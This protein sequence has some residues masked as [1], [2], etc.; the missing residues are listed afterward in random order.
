M[1]RKPTGGIWSFAT[2]NGGLNTRAGQILLPANQTRKMRNVILNLQG[3]VAK[4]RGLTEVKKLL[5]PIQKLM[6]YENSDYTYDIM[7]YNYPY[8][9]KVDPTSGATAIIKNNILNLGENPEY[10]QDNA[11]LMHIT[12]GVNAPLRYNGFTTAATTWPPVYTATNSAQVSS[13]YTQAANPTTEPF[14]HDCAFSGMRMVYINS[15]RGRIFFSEAN[16]TTDF[17][18]NAG[19]PV[20]LDVPFFA[21][22]P[23]TTPFTAILPITGGFILYTQNGFGRVAGENTPILGITDPLNFKWVNSKIGTVAPRMAVNKSNNEHFVYSRYGLFDIKLS[24]DFDQTRPGELSFDIQQDLDSIGIGGMARGELVNSPHE[25][26][27]YMLTPRYR[28][29]MY[30]D[31]IWKFNYEVGRRAKPK[32]TPWSIDEEFSGTPTRFDSMVVV[33]PKNDIFIAIYDTI[34]QYTGT[35]YLNSSAI[36]SEYEFPPND[37]GYNGVNK[38]ASAYWIIY[39]STTGA[40]IKLDHAWDNG[41]TGSTNIDLPVQIG[42]PLGEAIIGTDTYSS[43]AGYQGKGVRFPLSGGTVGKALTIKFIHNSS[44]EDIILYDLGVE[45]KVLGTGA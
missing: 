1:P 19:T 42:A 8:L 40:T 30:R 11:G 34:Y 35:S 25:G 23:V 2:V 24:E 12:D 15:T 14:P 4:S 27:L 43:D 3:G 38:Q 13:V 45:W 36:Q 9:T 20:P 10:A 44:T 37:F 22:Y 18:D 21:D 31:K 41:E 5:S 17:Q 29:H 33:P 26:I 6:L 28:T 16:D 32:T 39:K 7:S